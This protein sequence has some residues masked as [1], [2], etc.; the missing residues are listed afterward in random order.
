MKFIL[1][2]KNPKKLSEMQRI[3]LPLGVDV[4]SEREFGELPEAVEDGETFAQNARIKALSAMNA[5]G[6][7]AIADDSG[8]CVDAL[9][10]APGVYSARFSGDHDDKANNDKLLFELSDVPPEKRTARFV[11]NICCVFPN[12]DELTARG[13]CEGVI[14]YEPKGENGF[15]YDPLFMVGDKSFSELS[16]KQKDNISHRG[17]AMRDFAEKLKQFIKEQENDK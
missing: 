16:S 4:I 6:L 8:L 5:S 11:C 13:E 15:G 7:P 9:G 14:G 1:A 10:G 17:N 12:G 2:T 3:L